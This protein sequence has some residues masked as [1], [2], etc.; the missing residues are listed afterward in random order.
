MDDF[1]DPYAAGNEPPEAKI[2]TVEGPQKN[3]RLAIVGIVIG[4]IALAIFILSNIAGML[5]KPNVDASTAIA[6]PTTMNKAQGDSFAQSQA[7]H[8]DWMKGQDKD[9]AIQHNE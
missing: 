2:L 4:G 9:K 8:A 1:K 5:S 6:K 3:R 7:A